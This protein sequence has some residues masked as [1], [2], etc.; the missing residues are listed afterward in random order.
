MQAGHPVL[1]RLACAERRLAA[2]NRGAPKHGAHPGP[3]CLAAWHGRERGG[4]GGGGGQPS[5]GWGE[6]AGWPANRAGRRAPGP[7]A[8][9]L[10]TCSELPGGRHTAAVRRRAAGAAHPPPPFPAPTCLQTQMHTPS[11]HP[12]P[13]D[14]APQGA[15]LGIPILQHRK[16]L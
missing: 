13:V 11:T 12:P 14:H 1:L 15:E 7:A 8:G 16:K 2:V 4:G 5:M 6:L 10:H 3:A 9:R